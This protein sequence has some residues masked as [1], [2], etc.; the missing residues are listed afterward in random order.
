MQKDKT[1]I[2]CDRCGSIYHNQFIYFSADF[3]KINTL[4]G[5]QTIQEHPQLSADFCESCM[6]EIGRIVV[7]HYKPIKNGIQCELCGIV[8]SGTFESYHGKIT[9]ANVVLITGSPPSVIIDKDYLEI[10]VC[11]TDLEAITNRMEYLKTHT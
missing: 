9:K 2:Q 1:G 5:R 4:N 7:K 3:Y 8:Q 6:A 10:S 11:Q